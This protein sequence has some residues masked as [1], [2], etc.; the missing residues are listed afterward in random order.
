MNRVSYGVEVL[1]LS[2]ILVLVLSLDDLLRL[3]G[4]LSQ[5][6]T[7]IL[8]FIVRSSLLGLGL[9]LAL[10]RGGSRDRAG[11]VLGSG[12]GSDL[13]SLLLELGEALAKATYQ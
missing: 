5:G 7:L 4:L 13:A 9:G 3:L 12:G 11:T 2:L 8:I 1:R 10:A 6:S